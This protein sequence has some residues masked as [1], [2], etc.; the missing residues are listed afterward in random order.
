MGK[1]ACTEKP[2]TSLLKSTF[3]GYSWGRLLNQLAALSVASPCPSFVGRRPDTQRA[4]GHRGRAIAALCA[5]F[6]GTSS[7]A[8]DPGEEPSVT[9]Y[10]PSVSTPAAL[11]APGWL[12]LELGAQHTRGR[13]R[14]RRDTLPYTLKLA[15]SED[16]GVRV[17]GDAW[18]GQR[19]E[20]GDR[21]SGGGDTNLVLKRRFAL[22][23]SSAFGLEAGATLPTAKTGLGSGRSDYS[24]NGIYSADLGRYHTDLNLVATRVGQ[25][26]P[27]VSRN[28]ILWAASLSTALNDRWGVVGELWGTRQ[29]GAEHSAEFLAA[30]SY[31]VSRTM[32]LDAGISR[33]LRS[34]VPGWSV[35]TGLT[36]LL[37]RLF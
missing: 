14:S 37:G 35:F 36:V 23:D 17:G 9:P 10:R 29:S 6:L 11:S 26:D 33:S 15:F 4:N 2:A 30:A 8:A 7:H 32:T 19:D 12:E 25:V 1:S 20:A 3:N 24:V 27:G 34:Q 22:D 5:A 18:V 31:N 13:Q 16:W 28:Q 21:L